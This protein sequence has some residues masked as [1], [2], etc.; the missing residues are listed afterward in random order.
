MLDNLNATRGSVKRDRHA[1]HAHCFD[2]Y[3]AKRFLP[4]GH[5]KHIGVRGHLV[6]LLVRNTS[7][8]G[9]LVRQS[10][11]LELLSQRRILTTYDV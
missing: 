4:A 7:A 1:P 10:F 11:L 6:A 5:Q 8:P 2:G 3:H 9:D